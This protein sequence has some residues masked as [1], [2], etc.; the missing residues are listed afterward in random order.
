MTLLALGLVLLSAFFHATWNLFAKRSSGGVPFVWLFDTVSVLLY[1]PLLLWD[2]SRSQVTLGWQHLALILGSSLLHLGYF[3]SLQR[4]YR[5]G[6]LSLIYPLARGTGPLLSVLVA[7]LV[8]GERPTPLALVGGGLIVVSVFIFVGGAALF[9]SGGAAQKAIR[10]GLVTGVFIAAYTLF[11]KLSVSVFL[12][13]PLIYTTLG[14]AGRA[15]LLTPLAL[16]QWDRVKGE[17]REHRGAVFAVAIL[18]PLAYI[19]VLYAMTLAPISYVAPTRE[20]S[21]LIGA[22]M[23]LHFL[24]EGNV[25][26]RLLAAGV[27]VAGVV[28][29]ALG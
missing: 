15:L 17:W 27:M 26:Q 4:G 18:S 29:L 22:V 2:F 21:I 6:D 28:A 24:R 12:I 14:T 1:A 19:L 16:R 25:R 23:G 13:P 8:F 11:D 3:L 9:R 20:V 7:V 5:A 10:F